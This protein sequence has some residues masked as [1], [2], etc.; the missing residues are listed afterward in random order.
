MN[1]HNFP[2][3]PSSSH[4]P[5]A[6]IT[7]WFNPV[8]VKI[9]AKNPI[10][11]LF[12]YYR[13]KEIDI[14]RPSHLSDEEW[15]IVQEQ[16]TILLHLEMDTT[17]SIYNNLDQW[18]QAAQQIL[19][20]ILNPYIDFGKD[21]DG[22]YYSKIKL[23]VGLDPQAMEIN[24]NF[25]KFW[26]LTREAV[27]LNLRGP[28]KIITAYFNGGLGLRMWGLRNAFGYLLALSLDMDYI[29]KLYKKNKIEK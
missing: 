11:R 15:S 27:I 9:E 12:Q 17:K 14:E 23:E 18:T 22:N 4:H 8:E 10:A 20:L 16:A 28:D 13:D 26:E 5:S 1:E 2:I 3:N 21:A 7:S 25:E 19:V 29:K 24:Y 6:S